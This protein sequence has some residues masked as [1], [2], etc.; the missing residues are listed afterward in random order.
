MRIEI[1]GR[2][3]DLVRD[4]R[5]K[6]IVDGS[7]VVY[8]D[9]FADDFKPKIL[10]S[11]NKNKTPEPDFIAYRIVMNS[12]KDVCIVYEEHWKRQDC[13]WRELNKGH[14][15]DYEQ[16]QIHF[17]S[18]SGEI[19]RVV[20][21]STGPLVCAYHGVEVWSNIIKADKKKVH[22]VTSTKKNFPWG[23]KARANAQGVAM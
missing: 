2:T 16:I 22:Y 8:C 13:T 10:I 18:D 20:I 4:P 11:D 3:Y 15:H 5:D 12:D 1:Q 23:G 19:V 6:Y 7:I 9:E 17:N 14:E 21:S